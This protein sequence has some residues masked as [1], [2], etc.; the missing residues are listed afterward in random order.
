MPMSKQEKLINRLLSKPKDFEW[1]EAVSI[2]E[3]MG[4]EIIKGG[5][6]R[7]KFLHKESKT[8]ISLHEPHPGKIMKTYAI[9]E[10]ISALTEGGFLK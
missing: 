3:S 5:G 9:Q 4:F 1:A 8:V 10:I 7:R 6:S 2:L